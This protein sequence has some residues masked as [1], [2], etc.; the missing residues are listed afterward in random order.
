MSDDT[1]T[2]TGSGP[3]FHEALHRLADMIEERCPAATPLREWPRNYDEPPDVGW[4]SHLEA[5]AEG[6]QWHVRVTVR[7]M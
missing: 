4:P 7:P 2:I 5:W 6:D 1:R 3:L